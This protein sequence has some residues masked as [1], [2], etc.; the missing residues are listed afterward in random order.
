MSQQNILNMQCTIFIVNQYCLNATSQQNIEYAVYTIFIVNQYCF[1]ALKL[2]L[3]MKT[4]KCNTSE[5]CLT[6][7]VHFF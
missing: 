2:F 3:M 4:W 6:K 7:A 5:K 1:N